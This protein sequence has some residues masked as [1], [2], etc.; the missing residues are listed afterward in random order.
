VQLFGGK[1]VLKRLRSFVGS[2][3]HA[4]A[5]F[6]AIGSSLTVQGEDWL[7]FHGLER[8]GTAEESSLLWRGELQ[9]EWTTKIPGFG[10]SSPVVKGDKTYLTTAYETSEGTIARRAL[11][12]L[13]TIMAWALLIVVSIMVVRKGSNQT[14]LMRGFQALALMS[15]T[16]L[17]VSV[18]NFADRLFM[19]EHSFQ[20]SLKI[21]TLLS[22]AGFM[23]AMLLRPER[24]RRG[25]LSIGAVAVLSLATYSLMPRKELIG[26]FALPGGLIYTTLLVAPM[27]LVGLLAFGVSFFHGRFKNLGAEVQGDTRKRAIGRIVLYCGFPLVFTVV[28]ISGLVSRILTLKKNWEWDAPDEPAMQ[29]VFAPLLG[30]TSFIVLALVACVAI[31]I[32][33]RYALKNIKVARLLISFSAPVAVLLSLVCFLLFAVFPTKRKMAYAVICLNKDSGTIVWSKE[34][35]SSSTI[36]DFKGQNSHAT[37][38]IALGSAGLCAYFGEGGLFGLDLNGNIRWKVSDEQFDS[39]FGVGHSP[40]IDGNLVLLA[41]D[42]ESHPGKQNLESHIVAYDLNNGSVVWRQKR[43]RSRPGLAGFSSPIVRMISGRKT[44]VM[45]GWEDL[46]AYDLNTGAVLWSHRLKHTGNFLVAGLITDE[47][48]I[49]VSDGA[50]V[51]AFNIEALAA[52]KVEVE[53][54]ARIPGEKV[55]TPIL[56]DGL[57]FLATDTGVG[58]CI[59]VKSGEVEWRHKFG[60]RFFSSVVTQGDFVFFANEEGKLAILKRDPTF[61]MIA[62]KS[63][64]EKIYA[65]SVPLKDGLLLRSSSNLC[66]LKPSA[67]L[68]MQD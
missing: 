30:W 60:S 45:R 29:I 25:Y 9:P 54:L 52:G 18:I 50:G 2:C 5:L 14:G 38:T 51:K 28:A 33:S 19:L 31:V 7:G 64:G 63:M 42:N 36:W 32:G 59:N 35:G 68:T 46:T 8:Q 58:A 23:V 49:Y 16:L 37:P 34:V 44:V 11:A 22:T 21:A 6:L 62:E 61:T 67:S 17:L 47:E 12:Y 1:M 55:S 3:T 10:F 43:E 27:I 56:V 20:R 26:N 24:R 53:W 65:T 57:I 48:R 39:P 66:F 4:I 15:L 40:I 13:G 41:N